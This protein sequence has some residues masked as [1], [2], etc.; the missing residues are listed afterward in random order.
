MN[1]KQKAVI[2]MALAVFA[3]TMLAAPFRS[4]FPGITYTS[5]Y[6]SPDTSRTELAAVW[7]APDY[8]K[9]LIGTLL[10]EWVGIGIVSGVLV[11]LFKKPAP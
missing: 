10:V 1:K 4:T 11:L 2:W 3:L 5:G 9:L 6:R 8:G 7:N